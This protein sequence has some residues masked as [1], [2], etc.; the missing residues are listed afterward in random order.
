[1]TMHDLARPKVDRGLRG[2][3][4]GEAPAEPFAR[5]RNRSLHIKPVNANPPMRSISRRV[6][7]SHKRT[8]RPRMESMCGSCSE[9]RACPE[10]MP[11]MRPRSKYFMQNAFIKVAWLAWIAYDDCVGDASTSESS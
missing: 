2:E 4:E 9:L 11:E 10:I 8:R 1:M 3:G 5:I 7:R 6:M